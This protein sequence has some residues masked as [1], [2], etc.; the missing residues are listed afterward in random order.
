MRRFFTEPENINENTAVILED[1]SHI[2]KVLR[3]NSGDEILIFDGTG[4]EYVARL[5]LVDKDRCEAEIISS[6]FSRQEPEIKVTIYQGIPKSDKMEGIIQKSVELGVHSIVPVQM[7]RCVSKLDGG[8]KQ[9]DKLKRWNKISVEAAKQCGRGILPQIEEP[10]SFKEAISKMTKNGLAIMPYEVLAG[11]DNSTLKNILSS[12]AEKEF[13]VI[14]GPEGGFSD[15]EA[16]LAKDM[17]IHLVGLGPR[18]LR[19]ETVSSAILA[20]IMYEKNEM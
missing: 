11:E 16:A 5:T 2:T 12:T 13:S 3:M 14:I 4:Y 18:I 20:I 19:T 6:Y 9:V 10:L 7:D 17:G 1:A 15:S 8:K